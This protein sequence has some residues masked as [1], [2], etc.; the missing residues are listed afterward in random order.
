MGENPS[1]SSNLTPAVGSSR[2]PSYT[3]RMATCQQ[4]GQEN[5]PEASFCDACG[6]RL[7]AAVAPREVE[8]LRVRVDAV[9]VAHLAGADGRERL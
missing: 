6:A 1:V 9:V 2:E 7:E 5:R 3:R 4:C 8:A